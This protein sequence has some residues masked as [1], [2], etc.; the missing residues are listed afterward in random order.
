MISMAVRRQRSRRTTKP[1]RT[2][3]VVSKDKELK[4]TKY[5]NQ[6]EV[7]ELL[8]IK[9]FGDRVTDEKG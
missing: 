9:K 2:H 3:K 5:V 7:D 1:F 8:K 4:L 6:S